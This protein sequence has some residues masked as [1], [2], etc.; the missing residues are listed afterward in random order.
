MRK[1]VF[2][3]C[4]IIAEKTKCKAKLIQFMNFCKPNISRFEEY[5][6]MQPIKMVL[7]NVFC[8]YYGMGNIK[9]LH[10]FYLPHCFTRQKKKFFHI[11][12]FLF[13]IK[14][15]GF[16]FCTKKKSKKEIVKSFHCII[17]ISLNKLCKFFNE[18]KQKNL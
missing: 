13:S 6:C 8:I 14:R 15:L 4:Q 9:Y 16:T 2:I 10:I 12:Y 18:G 3:F 7:R 5:V 17:K 11:F 1:D